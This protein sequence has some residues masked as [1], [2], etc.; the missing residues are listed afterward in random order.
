MI[1]D[2]SLVPL[3][4]IHLNGD[5]YSPTEIVDEIIKYWSI[6][7]IKTDK[8]DKK[9]FDSLRRYIER[10]LK[11]KGISPVEPSKGGIKRY[12]RKNVEAI[13]NS[14]PVRNHILK[15]K[16][17]WYSEQLRRLNDSKSPTAKTIQENLKK[18]DSEKQ[19]IPCAEAAAEA[20]SEHM[21]KL[22]ASTYDEEIAE[23]IDAEIDENEKI[24][25]AKQEIL[26]QVLEDFIFREVIKF[27]EEA[28]KADL[29][30]V[31]DAS[32]LYPSLYQA[33][34]NER[35]LD[36]RNYYKYRN[37]GAFGETALSQMIKPILAE[38]RKDINDDIRKAL[39]E[40]F[41]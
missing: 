5:S 35:L 38:L 18:A 24:K 16:K 30:K 39:K 34:A 33:Y 6:S 7:L 14:T 37:D 20:Y 32:D 25:R 40:A 22:I 28:Y 9:K 15:I 11:R 23:A 41:M 36:L 2:V 27:D 4:E 17:D 12:D 8:E 31:P 26:S 3:E 10:A 21:C 1:D 29:K 19:A 13:L